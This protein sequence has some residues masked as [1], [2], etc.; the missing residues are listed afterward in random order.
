MATKLTKGDLVRSVLNDGP[1]YRVEANK[2]G[3]LTV[4]VAR[5]PLNADLVYAKQ[6]ASIFVRLEG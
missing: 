4:R 1:V 2:N 3:W 6:R 5:D